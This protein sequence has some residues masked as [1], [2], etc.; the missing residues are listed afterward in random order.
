MA[1]EC[2][3]DERGIR[4]RRRLG[5]ILVGIG[6]AIAGLL[7]MI[8]TAY[9]FT[10]LGSVGFILGGAFCLFEAQMGW[11]AVRALGFRTKI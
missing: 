5:L 7:L 11:C 8:D 2:N 10:W 1:L 4:F 3:I 9:G 6:L